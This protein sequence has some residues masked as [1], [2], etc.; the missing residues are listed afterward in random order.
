MTKNLEHRFFK[1]LSGLPSSENI[2][3]LEIP[4]DKEEN[5]KA[6]Y[7]VFNR[8]LIVEV[9]T[10]KIDQ[11]YKVDSEIDKHRD[12]DDFPII[13]GDVELKKILAH[14]PDGE[15]INTKIFEKITR[16]IEQ[17]FRSANKQIFDT[18]D[19]F[20]INNSIGLLVILNESINILSP[21][22]IV[23]KISQMLTKKTKDESIRYNNLT[24][25]W[26]INESHFTHI[27]NKIKYVPSIIVEGP[28]A[29]SI[30][31]I[32]NIY[33]YLQKEWASFNK[34]PVFFSDEKLIK[35]LTFNT[36]SQS[37]NVSNLVQ[38]K[39]EVWRR[40]YKKKP[41][42]RKLEEY[43]LIDY[44]SSLIAEMKPYFIKGGLKP[45]KEH[46]EKFGSL[47]THFMEE[48]NFR[49]MDW[50]KIYKRM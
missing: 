23:W 34:V 39:H 18:K 3:N 27:Q 26:V 45:T 13:Y 32:G 15:K 7:F 2:D 43:E 1:Y 20:Q 36:I 38:P 49:G 40:D 37:E 22:V 35:N 17:A 47:F 24:S 9:K 11:K 19:T 31:N 4:S 8:E 5:Q 41:Y 6:D 50:R 28:N 33:N 46:F 25:V 44:G 42:L 12:R 30:E 10:L 29:Q 16:S 14:L 48:M 21:D